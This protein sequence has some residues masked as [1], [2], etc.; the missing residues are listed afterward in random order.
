MCIESVGCDVL[1]DVN[2]SVEI[3]IGQRGYDDVAD[4]AVVYAG[5]LAYR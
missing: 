1:Q 4:A 5:Y 2:R 3:A